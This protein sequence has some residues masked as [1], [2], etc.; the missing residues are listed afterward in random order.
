MPCPRR[1]LEPQMGSLL[2]RDPDLMDL[3]SRCVT[4]VDQYGGVRLRADRLP[5]ERPAVR[6]TPALQGPRGSRRLGPHQV[7]FGTDSWWELSLGT[8]IFL[9]GN[10]MH[11][12]VYGVLD[13]TTSMS[14]IAPMDGEM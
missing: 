1:N 13:P 8:R 10:P 3:M 12:G 9:G 4:L 14:R 6:G 11:M 2:F 5:S 7:L